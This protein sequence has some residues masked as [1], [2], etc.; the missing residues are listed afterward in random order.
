M[1]GERAACN[2][3]IA[4][5]PE[6]IPEVAHPTFICNHDDWELAYQELS[7]DVNNAVS[8]ACYAF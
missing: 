1:T 3:S 8:A 5:V 2:A 7:M 6:D 4:N